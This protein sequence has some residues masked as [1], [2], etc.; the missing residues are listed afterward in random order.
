M[1]TLPVC[2]TRFPISTSSPF[3]AG[4]GDAKV[5]ETEA[6]SAQANMKSAKRDMVP[7]F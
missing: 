1:F 3:T 2:E 4:T 6:R 5:K 7:R